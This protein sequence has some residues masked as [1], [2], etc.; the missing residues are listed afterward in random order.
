M[1]CKVAH[2]LTTELLRHQYTRCIGLFMCHQYNRHT[3]TLV[4]TRRYSASSHCSILQKTTTTKK[5]Y[6]TQAAVMQ[7]EK[8]SKPEAKKVFSTKSHLSKLWEHLPLFTLS[9]YTVSLKH[10]FKKKKNT[11]K[12]L[13]PLWTTAHSKSDITLLTH[14]VLWRSFSCL[15]TCHNLMFAA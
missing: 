12:T 13:S 14:A 1:V 3:T 15:S 2:R 10:W 8:L 5:Q 4:S 9:F 6:A 11:K 7:K